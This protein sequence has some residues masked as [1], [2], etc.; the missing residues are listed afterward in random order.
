[1]TC[2]AGSV[3]HS[4]GLGILCSEA[5]HKGE[6]AVEHSTGSGSLCS[7]ALHKGELAV[8]HSTGSGRTVGRSELA[9]K[10]FH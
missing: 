10:H 6:L 7:G 5:L 4:T 3:E 8:K 9:V 2:R 1:M